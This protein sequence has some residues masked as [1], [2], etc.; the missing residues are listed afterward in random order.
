MWW[1]PKRFTPTEVVTSVGGRTFTTR[2]EVRVVG[3][4]SAGG[5]DQKAREEAFVAVSTALGPC[6]RLRVAD[7]ATE[8]WRRITHDENAG[9]VAVG[10][11]SFD[12]RF[13]VFCD[14]IAFVRHLTPA[15]TAAPCE[16]TGELELGG[17]RITVH[18]NGIGH[19]ET[20]ANYLNALFLL[21]PPELRR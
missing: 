9:A 17:G 3:L 12:D 11:A 5:G 8:D 20:A 4:E 1:R 18:R 21:L 13:L 16:S 10:V 7:R 2:T 14:E 6:P 15:L 19:D